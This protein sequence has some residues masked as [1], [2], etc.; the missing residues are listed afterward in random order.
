MFIK[1]E[2]DRY[3]SMP[4]PRIRL[5]ALLFG[6]IGFFAFGALAL[7]SVFEPMEIERVAKNLIR[8]EVERRTNEE[9]RNLDEY[10][11]GGRA[12]AFL[13]DHEA[14]VEQAEQALKERLPGKIAEVIA[15]MQNPDC[16]CRGKVQVL[17]RDWILAGISSARQAA[18]PLDLLVRAEYQDASAKLLREFRIFTTV[19]AL[20]F[21]ALAL[22]A[23]RRPA[24]N[25]LLLPAVML[26]ALSA[27]MTA[28]LYLFRQDWIHTIVFNQYL[29]LTYVAY[30]ALVF[31]FLSDILFNRGRV[32][33]G[34][35]TIA[36]EAAGSAAS[37][38]PC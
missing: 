16:E 34:F 31:L 37:F 12:E 18:E 19:N 32:T 11:L 3:I 36:A 22:A 23:L 29:G 9:V 4:W 13:R 33:A 14:D 15:K 10:F 21:V 25:G 20:V 2:R 27:G 24:A 28:Y 26:L 17:V 1:G 7:I 30:L 38:P 35:M 5:L 6:G 8:I